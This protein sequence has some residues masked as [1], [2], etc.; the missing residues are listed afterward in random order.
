[1][2]SS[3]TPT[4]R[5]DIA[6]AHTSAHA[7]LTG[8]IMRVRTGPT[9]STEQSDLRPAMS[10]AGDR[11]RRRRI[12]AALLALC[13][14]AAVLRSP[15][16]VL[17]LLGTSAPFEVPVTNDR[18]VA[19]VAD[20]VAV[21][22]GAEH[23]LTSAPEPDRN[24]GTS[25]GRWGA[26][27][28]RPGGLDFTVEELRGGWRVE[29]GAEEAAAL[30]VIAAHAWA[31]RHGAP[32]SGPES[33]VGASAGAGAGAIVAVEA[34]ERPG[35][36]HAVVTLLVAAGQELHRIAVPIAFGAEGPAI[37]GAAWPL[38]APNTT[39]APSTGTAIGDPELIAS[40]RRALDAVGIPGERLVALEATEGWPF[41]ARLEDDADGHP[42]LRWHL[43]RFVVSGLPLRSGGGPR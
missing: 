10:R 2:A 11:H 30:A 24:G 16:T 21:P 8:G 41:I 29:A 9:G 33:G 18:S 7:T 42:W 5:G 40:A 14:V 27:P 31:G 13:I 37:A 38:P 6:A 26:S 12:V 43:D 4:H 20:G 3:P 23:G 17:T 22:P 15:S 34:V 1:M 19:S 36:L 28:I 35:A 25:D 39:T 32:A